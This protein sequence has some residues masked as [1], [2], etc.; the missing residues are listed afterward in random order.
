MVPHFQCSDLVGMLLL[1]YYINILYNI[2]TIFLW[3]HLHLST[4]FGNRF[5]KPKG[6]RSYP[7]T[8]VWGSLLSLHIKNGSNDNHHHDTLHRYRTWDS[9][10]FTCP[11]KVLKIWKAVKAASL[12]LAQRSS[13]LSSE[14]EVPCY[15][16][17]AFR[18]VYQLRLILIIDQSPIEQHGQPHD[19]MTWMFNRKL[20]YLYNNLLEEASSLQ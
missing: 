17:D 3:H 8:W 11:L 18:T 4:G 12:C 15:S 10:K 19:A 2:T 7:E 14:Q 20:L 13:T 9:W 16:S 1:Q 6:P 5:G